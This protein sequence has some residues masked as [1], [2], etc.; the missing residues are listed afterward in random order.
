MGIATWICE[1]QKQKINYHYLLR[2]LQ[3]IQRVVHVSHFF[4]HELAVQP[5][6]LPRVFDLKKN[7]R[8][9]LSIL[10]SSQIF[11]LFLPILS[12]FRQLNFVFYFR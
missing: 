5:H 11:K 8:K 1:G 2:N 4:G 3:I 12:L 7:K 9:I 6:R 10:K